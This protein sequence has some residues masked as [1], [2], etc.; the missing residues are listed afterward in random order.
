MPAVIDPNVC[1]RHFA[2]CFPAR[3]CP[4]TAFSFD[5]DLEQ[6]IINSDLC[7]ACPG[8]CTNFCD[9]YAIRFAADPHEFEMLK[10]KTLGTLTDA[11]AAEELARLKEEAKA[12]AAGAVINA[13]T[14]TFDADVLQS[15]LPVVVDFWAPWCGPCKVMAPVF[16]RIAEQY[17]DHVRF[18]KVD[19]EAEPQIAMRYRIQSIPTLGFFWRGQLIDALI[20]AQPESRLQAVV[21]QFLTEVRQ[22][23]QQ[24]AADVTADW[25]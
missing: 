12:A 1:D 8:P 15:D 22:L 21:Y 5:A 3:M 7:G 9:R 6:V 14:Q 19:T 20:G 24:P 16:E 18:V 2:G 10:G 11:Q 23:E 25:E 13:T 4:Q 17:K